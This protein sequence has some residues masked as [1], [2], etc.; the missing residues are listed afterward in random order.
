MIDDDDEYDDDNA[1]DDAVDG[2]D[3]D[4]DVDLREFASANARDTDSDHD[5]GDHFG[6]SP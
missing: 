3:E 6:G 2:D 4:D 5:F 1:D